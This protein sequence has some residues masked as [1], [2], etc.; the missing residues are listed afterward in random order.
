VKRADLKPVDIQMQVHN[1]Q[2]SAMKIDA[3]NTAVT[4]SS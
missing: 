1:G 4:C 3:N 2:I